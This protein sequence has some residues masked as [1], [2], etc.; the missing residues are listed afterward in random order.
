MIGIIT[1]L[2]D[3]ELED[4]VIGQLALGFAEGAVIEFR[5]LNEGDLLN[6]LE[7]MPTSDSRMILVHDLLELPKTIRIQLLQK[8]HIISV[9]VDQMGSA[10]SVELNRYVA[11]TFRRTD[12]KEN[13]DRNLAIREDLVVV[14]GSTGGSGVST[15]ALNLA[16]E[17]ASDREICLVDAHPF[18][19][20]LAF[21]L[22]GKRDREL[23]KLRT[24]LTVSSGELSPSAKN[25][26]DIG[27]LI[28]LK[29]AMSDRRKPARDYLEFLEVASQLIFVMQPDNNHMFEL[30]NVLEAFES[31]KYRARPLFLINQLGNSRRERS[32]Y[33]RFTARVGDLDSIVIP[34]DRNN[35]DLAKAQYCALLD[36][37]PRSKMR[38]AIRQVADQIIE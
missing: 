7:A 30:D 13:P 4:R 3:A 18:R 27:P 2:H 20:D 1:F 37:S 26:V 31:G 38:K 21:M 10:S 19:K 16:V 24:G 17:L 15:I 33:K 34:Y 8:P 14:T 6:Y 5:A 11:S 9:P 12:L 25:I 35:I 29:S 36:V 23:T 28:D 32:I 22:G